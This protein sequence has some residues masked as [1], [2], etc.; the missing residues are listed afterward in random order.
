MLIT[1]TSLKEKYNIKIS[2]IVHIGAH[3][4]EELEEY[5]ENKIKNI[6]FFEPLN[7]SF[8]ILESKV[9]NIDANII[10]HKVALGNEVGKKIMYLSS[11]DGQ[12]SS[13]LKPKEHLIDHPHVVFH[14][15]EEVTVDMLDN[16]DIGNSNFIN[17][18]VQGYEL[19]VF[20]GASNSLDKIDYIYCEVNR[21]E[22][23]EGNPLVEDID[24]FLGKYNFQR[25]ETCWPG[26]F[27]WGDAFYIKK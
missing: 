14:D 2:G 9:Q 21:G 8:S 6:I 17:I 7:E 16:F 24:Q 11:N 5:I 25:V 12:S 10:C 22:V 13:I 26:N 1:F 18:D 3:Y 19:E 23:Y 4:G 20:R 27:K 15:T